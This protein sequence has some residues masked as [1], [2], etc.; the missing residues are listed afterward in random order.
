QV[1]RLGLSASQMMQFIAE[2]FEGRRRSE[3]KDSELVTLLYHLQN[4]D[5]KPLPE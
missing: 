5:P 2:K 3:L 1:Q 4:V